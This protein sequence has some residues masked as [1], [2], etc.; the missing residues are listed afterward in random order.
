MNADGTEDVWAAR[1]MGAAG[2]R[3]AAATH[4]LC[5]TRRWAHAVLAQAA[6]LPF[7]AACGGATGDRP[8]QRAVSG[9]V[10]LTAWCMNYALHNNAWQ[11]LFD[12]WHAKEPRVRV[13]LEPQDQWSTKYAAAVAADTTPDLATELGTGTQLRFAGGWY[14]PLDTVYRDARIDPKRYF[15]PSA[16]EPWE[17]QGKPYG[18][19]FEDTGPGFGVVLRTDFIKEAGQPVP[20]VRLTSWDETYELAKRLVKRGGATGGSGSGVR[21]GWTTR[22][23]WLTLWL[24][25]AMLDAGQEF[26]DKT[27]QRFQVNTPA[28]VDVLK[29]L[30]WDPA[31]VHGIEPPEGFPNAQAALKAGDAAMGI[32]SQATIR[33]ARS[34]RRDSAPFLDFAIRPPFKGKDA[35]ILGHG[36]WGVSLFR[37]SRQ[38][39]QAAP[40]LTYLMGE[41]ARGIWTIAGDCYATAT[42]AAYKAP[43]WTHTC[44]QP[45]FAYMRGVWEVQQAGN[46]RFYG[47]E[48]GSP[49]DAYT[50]MNRITDELRAGTLAPKRA[51]EMADEEL[52][53]KHAEFRAALAAAGARK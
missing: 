31:H 49:Q 15:F 20:P 42:A 6:A 10:D 8:P 51:A 27:R 36:G 25:G 41:R 44:S 45:Q 43:E 18:I 4:R 9:P 1:G 35:K 12:D 17:F 3:H 40:F 46:L 28:G 34:E 7:L 52:T 30:I 26:F 11:R 14:E 23:S 24:F 22:A 33:D 53:V 47:N 19:P 13:K 37:G 29:K 39:E 48:A 5:Q 38:K 32:N 21:W 16:Y 50:I 2:A